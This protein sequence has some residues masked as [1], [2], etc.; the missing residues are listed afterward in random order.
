MTPQQL[1]SKLVVWSKRRIV[2]NTALQYATDFKAGS[3]GEGLIKDYF[4]SIEPS[5]STSVCRIP[6]CTNVTTDTYCTQ[7]LNLGGAAEAIFHALGALFIARG[8]RK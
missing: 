2:Y 3:I 7:C 4:L 5:V 8:Q 1:A 6:T